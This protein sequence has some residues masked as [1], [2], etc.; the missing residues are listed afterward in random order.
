MLQYSVTEGYGPLRAA[1]RDYANRQWPV[2]SEADDL[3]ITSGSQ[4]I[5]E[6]MTKLLCNEGDVIAVEEPAFLGAYNSMR[7]FGAR[8][9][10][11]PWRRTAWI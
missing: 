3:I 5:I 9:A 10:G 1:A 6:F 2:V 7:S 11:V 4:Q 8:L